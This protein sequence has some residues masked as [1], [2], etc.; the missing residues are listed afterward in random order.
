M[1][2]LINEN[3]FKKFTADYARQITLTSS[4]VEEMVYDEI[5]KAA[6]QNRKEAYIHLSGVDSEIIN[7]VIKDLKDNGYKVTNDTPITHINI[8]W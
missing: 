4:Y 7:T 1:K 8:E 6:N 2:T 3:R 5:S